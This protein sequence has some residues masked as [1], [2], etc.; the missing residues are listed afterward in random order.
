[1]L[2]LYSARSPAVF[3]VLIGLEE[4]G[5][6]FEDRPVNIPQGEQLTPEVLA[7]SPNG[8]VPAL[9]DTEPADGGAPIPV[10]ES[11]A[12][13]IYLA[14][15]YG[16]LLPTGQRAR[17]AVLEWVMWQMAGLG[18]MMGQARHFR[19]F[20]LE[21][22]PYSVERFT[23]EVTRLF[24]VLDRRLEGRT[25]ICDAYS[26]ADICCWPW[27]LFARSNGQDLDAFVHLARW[28]RAV[29]ERPAVQRVA[30]RWWAGVPIEQPQ[31]LDAKTRSILFGRTR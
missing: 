10:F 3:K 15:K 28:F 4:L 1:M 27:L 20:T 17:T 6:E 7:F 11:G 23:N 5:L 9:V 19:H 22:Q 2:K 14:E 26:I 31:P 16:R 13:L 29:Q 18:P 12:I 24:S 8:R 25:F 30:Q 21:P